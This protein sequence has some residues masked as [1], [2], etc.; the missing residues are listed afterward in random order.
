MLLQLE[1]LAAA[2]FAELHERPAGAHGLDVRRR[3]GAELRRVLV[4]IRSL[5]ASRSCGARL[6]DQPPALSRVA[7]HEFVL[8]AEHSAR[9]VRRSSIKP[10]RRPSSTSWLL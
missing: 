2:A 3:R 6:V 4:S 7:A 10:A 5:T 8:P 1:V 9:A